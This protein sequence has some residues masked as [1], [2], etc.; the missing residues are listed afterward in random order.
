MTVAAPSI[1][2][3]KC[4]LALQEELFSGGRPVECPACRSHL[5]AAFF[6]AFTAPPEEGFTSGGVP[7]VEG[8]ATCFFHPANRATLACESCGRFLCGLCDLP[9]GARHLCAACIGA[10]KPAELITSRA[11]WSMAALLAGVLPLVASIFIWPLLI[12]TGVFAIFL[13]LWGWRKPGS[14][15]KGP[16]RWAAVVGLVCGLLQIGAV[17]AFG[18][19][20][21]MALQRS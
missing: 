2:C 14:L 20:L 13:A 6:P 10:R 17:A 3:P 16:R 4:A 1:R 19:F 11:C 21:W 8:E 18:G 9:F 7:A 5:T 12:F 15:V